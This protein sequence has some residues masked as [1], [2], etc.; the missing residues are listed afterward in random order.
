MVVSEVIDNVPQFAAVHPYLPTHWWN[1]FDALLR[2]PVDTG[3][4]G[5]GLL[6]FGIYTLL[7]GSIAWARFSTAD[8]TS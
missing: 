2:V 6:S 7:W 8:V 3:T 5:R 1:S 4:L